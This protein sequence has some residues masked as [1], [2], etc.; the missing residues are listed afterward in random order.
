LCEQRPRTEVKHEF[1]VSSPI[2]R[3][4][5]AE[6]VAEILDR[7]VDGEII[8]VGDALII[9]GAK[10]IANGSSAAASIIVEHDDTL[11]TGTK[12]WEKV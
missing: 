8:E 3:I 2:R 12:E 11:E 9:D 6:S 5:T 10:P 1:K 7:V 4:T